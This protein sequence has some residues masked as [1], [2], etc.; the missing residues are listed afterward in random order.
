MAVCMCG[1]DLREVGTMRKLIFGRNVTV[2]GYIAATG[3]D[4]GWSGGG[5]PDSSPSEELFLVRADAGG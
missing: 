1:I 3:D 4:I 2:D 5:G